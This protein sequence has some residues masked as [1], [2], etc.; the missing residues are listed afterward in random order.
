MRE[1][2]QQLEENLIKQLSE[3]GYERIKIENEKDLIINLRNQINIHNKEKLKEPLTDNEFNR[4]LL[5]LSSGKQFDKAITLREEYQLKRDDNTEIYINF[6]NKIRWC[7]NTFQ[8]CN[9]IKINGKYDNRYDTTILINGLPLVQ[10]ELKRRGLGLSEA[11][12]Q[13]QRYKKDSYSS[14]NSLFD[15]IQIFVISNG[16]DTKYFSNN[17]HKNLSIKQLYFWA[18]E[19]NKNISEL[20]EF[21]E[22]FLEKCMLSKIIS[23]YMF[24]TVDKKLLVIRPYQYYAAERC[25][26]L[27]LNQPN[28]NG[29]IWHTTGSGKTLTSFKT[30]QLIQNMDNVDKVIFVVDRKDLDEQTEKEFNKFKEGSVDCTTDTKALIKQF[31][32]PNNKL[33]LTTIQ[34]LNFA[35]SKEKNKRK[36]EYFRNKKIIFIFDECHRTQFGTTH[37]NII[38]FF[39]RAQ[40]L[41]FTGT[42]IFTENASY[43]NGLLKTTQ[44]LFGECLHK[45]LITDAIADNNVLKFNVEFIGKYKETSKNYIDIEV[46]NIDKKE[47]LAAE[48]RAEKIV[49]FIIKNHDLKT[50][51]RKFNSIFCVDS[52]EMLI[53]YYKIFKEKKHTLKIATIFSFSAN[54]EVVFDEE[55]YE[56]ENIYNHRDKL[57]EYISDYNKMFNTNY[58]TKDKEFEGY[59]R[60]LS[61]KV[62]DT[63][64]DILLVVNMFLTGFDAPKL[65]TLYVDKYLKSHNILQ[66][67]SRTNRPFDLLKS[68]GNIVCF[69]NI[70]QDMDNAITLFSNRNASSDIFIKEYEE[71][72]SEFN[73]KTKELFKIAINPLDLN[74]IKDE[75]ELREFILSFRDLI[76]LRNILTNFNDFSYIDLTLNEEEFCNFE[77]KYKDI[78]EL[79][80]LNRNAD[81]VSVLNDIDFEIEL[82]QKVE[83]NVNYI[84]KLLK[85]LKNVKEEEK[86]NKKIEIHKII[87]KEKTL[88]SKKDL[89][90]KFIEENLEHLDEEEIEEKYEDFLSE[91][92]KKELKELCMTE[93]LKEDKVGELISELIYINKVEEFDNHLLDNIIFKN[94]E[95]GILQRESVYQR[96]KSKITIFIKRFYNI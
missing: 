67:F 96:I 36:I 57:E 4:I 80:S 28:K 19:E 95:P 56:E 74:E 53:K 55:E 8:V 93:Y 27:V 49:D 38:N 9:Q 10:I 23:Q 70:K 37:K 45:Y 26:E 62:K 18:N 66:S 77:S 92:R 81:K 3:N 39:T 82:L 41:G 50:H 86:E 71:Y 46:E 14:G 13:I 58:S 20:K 91:E 64:I 24:L 88:K 52:I 69:R 42:P 51:N 43:H 40:L 2:E 25:K 78:K 47:I 34:K 44:S 75:I 30:A 16:I 83:I 85:E 48:E 35:V 90:E 21:T 79:T 6:F 61:K 12:N 72:V 33:I 65:N 15:Y 89:I 73:D 59:F 31:L 60:H 68:H 17:S 5:Y 94:K 87:E 63:E 11:F 29:F 22:T 1:T 84:F 32:D 76:R 54:S 7:Q